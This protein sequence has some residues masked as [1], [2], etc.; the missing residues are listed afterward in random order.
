MRYLRLPT[1]VLCC[2]AGAAAPL[3][4]AEIGADGGITLTVSFEVDPADPDSI[5]APLTD[6]LAKTHYCDS[7]RELS[8][9]LYKTTEGKHWV[10]RVRFYR[11]ALVRDIRWHYMQS[12][13]QFGTASLFESIKWTENGLPAGTA[14][15]YDG[16]VHGGDI[17]AP[18]SNGGGLN[19]EMGHFFYGLP[20]EYIYFPGSGTGHTGLCE[21]S[22][23]V[24]M[25][26]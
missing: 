8:K 25:G 6:P 9:A 16:V 4:A 13:G 14:D 19:H 2:A 21:E 5:E 26:V 15:P 7:I 18:S 10:K 11:N 20:D 23:S 12:G 17:A 24:S 22:Y 3:R 1:L